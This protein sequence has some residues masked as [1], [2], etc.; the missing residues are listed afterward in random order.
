MKAARYHGNRDVRIDEVEPPEP[1]AGEVLIDVDA[2]GIC[3]SD[4]GEYLH[5]PRRDD[6][7]YLPYTMGHELGGT[8]AAVGDG[9]DVEVGTEVGVNPLVACESCWC[10]DAGKYNLCRNLEVIGAHRQG[11]YAEQVVAPVGNV[12]ELPEGLSPTDAA[13][14]EPL[15]VAYHGLLESPLRPGH[16]AVVVGLGPIGLG[17]VQLATA[18]GASPVIASGHRESRRRLAAVC[19]ADVVV[20]PRETDLAARVAE[21]TDGGAD[22]SFEVAG[23]GSALNDAITATKASGHT[24]V[25]GV[26]KGPVE[27]DPMDFVNHERTINGSAAYETGPRADREF[28]AVYEM[29]ASGE[30]DA[31]P[32][33]T[34]RIPLDNIVEDGFEPLADSDSGEVKVLVEP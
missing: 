18:A 32:L 27:V 30:V 34:S 29:L 31:G 10:C 28:G 25:L 15:T 5:G 21:E 14:A 19:G 1:K 2:C 3:G 4:L 16:S 11:G 20:D 23:N 8:V 24:T 12:I 13:V 26:F 9:V 6:D 33:V 22:V 7:G 17:M